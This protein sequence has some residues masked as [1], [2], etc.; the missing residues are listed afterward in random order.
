MA[1]ATEFDKMRRS[2][3][4]KRMF[5]RL[6]AGLI[7][8]VFALVCFI[9]SSFVYQL[10]LGSRVDNFRA[11]LQSGDGFPVPMDDLTILGLLPMGKDVAVVTSAGTYLY[12]SHGALTQ[13]CLNDYRVPQAKAAGGKLLTYDLG[14]TGLRVDNKRRELYSTQVEGGTLLAADIAENG[15][16]AMAQSIAGSYAQVTAYNPRFEL[17][18]SW[19]VPD[20][21]ITDVALSQNGA[22]MSC[23]GVTVEGQHMVALLRIHHF[24]QDQEVARISLTDQVIVSMVWTG[25]EEIQVVTDKAIY[26]FSKTGEQLAKAELPGEL[27][28]Y[29]NVPGAVYVAY[30]DYRDP[31]GVVI[32]AYSGKMEQRGEAS[33][34]RKVLSLTAQGN[35]L[36]VLTEGQ[37][38]LGDS[39]L[40][41]LKARPHEGLYWVC[42]A[43]SSI[44]GITPDGLIRESL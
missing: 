15:A 20:S 33:V 1:K 35:H 30:G 12:N 13:M 5:R 42:S 43:G 3:R 39:S 26:L 19:K 36:L 4:R 2:R 44:Y 14:G 31:E 29:E 37:L 9:S 7:L 6:V 27:V 21:Y 17:M 23:A 25:S 16:I 10:D 8:L 11:S 32:L 24:D 41:E 18:Y 40:R 38:Y 34:D 22:M 28:T